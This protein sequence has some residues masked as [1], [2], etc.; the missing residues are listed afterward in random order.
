MLYE[1]SKKQEKNNLSGTLTEH[2]LK[3]TMAYRNMF[4][5]DEKRRIHEFF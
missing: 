5:N 3:G 2:R 4:R 1:F